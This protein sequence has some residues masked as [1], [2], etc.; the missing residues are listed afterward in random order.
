MPQN[1]EPL[2]LRTNPYV[3]PRPYRRGETLY[4]RNQESAELADLLIA[5]RI[6]M[7][8]SPSGAGKSSLL[9]ASVIPKLEENGFDVLPVAR[10]NLEPPTE[11]EQGESFNR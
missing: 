4:G 8:Y 11:S 5:E 2:T 9:N 10:L 1:T 6:M 7:L 3:G